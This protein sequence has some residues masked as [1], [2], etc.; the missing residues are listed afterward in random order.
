[1][2]AVLAK[3]LDASVGWGDPTRFRVANM[4]PSPKYSDHGVVRV[5][6][7]AQ[8]IQRV[9][10]LCEAI[11]VTRVSDVTGLDRAGIP[12]FMTVRP[13][14]ADGIS[15]YNG[16]GITR[17]AAKAGALME[18]LERYS[19]EI[20]D[21]PVTCCTRSEIE[22]SGP[23]VDPTT[24]IQPLVS[25]YDL[26]TPLDWVQGYDL[27]GDQPVYVPLNV[28]VCPYEPS[29]GATRLFFADTNG[30]A[31]GNTIE[32]A[33]CHAI[34][35]VLERDAAAMVDAGRVLAVGVEALRA[36][37]KPGERA[38][39]LLGVGPPARLIDL[40]TL[41]TRQLKVARKMRRAG[42]TVHVRDVTGA[43]G[44]PSFDCVCIERKLDG[45]H[46]VHGGAGAH[47]DARVAVSR[48]LTEAA[49]SRLSHI[50]G[51]REDLPHILEHNDGLCDPENAFGPAEMRSFAAVKSY[52]HA[53]IDDDIRFM[54]DR[55]PRAGLDRVIAVD[56]TR[57][58]LGVPVVCVVIPGTETWRMYFE[59]GCFRSQL[60]LRASTVLH[61][62]LC[63]EEMPSG[64]DGARGRDERGLS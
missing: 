42:L 23:A 52:E 22:R 19:G 56:L 64:D 53:T 27:L 59:H 48:A 15:Y 11:G 18:A 35:E 3:Q 58:E 30:L 20:C 14:D 44:I 32:E 9:L 16:K 49:Q 38:R 37:A 45:H 55:I 34:C 51:G 43:T 63:G 57:P 46:L 2:R 4:R 10:P 61:A 17:A 62:A 47:P 25:R 7:P 54:L 40:E 33:I 31:S 26:S 6:P 24:L 1:M 21:L 60:G 36:L 29:P 13:R 12:N 8:T 28:V 41:P 50:Q 39:D 5:I